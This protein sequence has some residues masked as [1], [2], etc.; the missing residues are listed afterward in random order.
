MSD[1][2]RPEPAI[3]AAEV[4]PPASA[5]SETTTQPWAPVHPIEVESYRI[6]EER[7]D[8]SGWPDGARDVVA[9]VIHSTADL[10][11]AHAMRVG[12]EA[13]EAAVQALRNGAPVVC[14]AHMLRVGLTG[15][16]RLG[17]EALC[18]L[19]EVPEAP[20]GSTRSA[21]AI[22]RAAQRHPDDAIWV[23]GNAPT[24]LDELLTLHE[25]G[26]V[27]PVAVV[28]LPVGFVGAAESKARL[29]SSSLQP[30]AITNLGEKGGTPAAAGAVNALC[31]RAASDRSQRSGTS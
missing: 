13:V 21:Q 1:V 11:Y 29:W 30:R 24:A 15:L 27:Q 23:V 5:P 25:N 10:D 16:A 3:R 17:S 2:D 18:L 9:R 26:Q 7:I 28:G 20:P 8:L 6:L 19:D 14:D 31:R 4:A 22:R 12:D